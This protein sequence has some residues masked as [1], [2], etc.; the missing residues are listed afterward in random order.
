MDL[1]EN[2]TEAEILAWNENDSKLSL[3]TL[4]ILHGTMSGC[5]INDFPLT[6]F[7]SLR[8]RLNFVICGFHI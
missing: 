6:N 5:C 7:T 8:L 1:S 2:H 3:V 4:A